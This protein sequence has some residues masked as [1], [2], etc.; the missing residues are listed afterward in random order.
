MMSS[1]GSSAWRYPVTVISSAA[2]GGRSLR[3]GQVVIGRRH[4]EEPRRELLVFAIRPRD[5]RRAPRRR[6]SPV[7]TNVP[8]VDAAGGIADERP[9]RFELHAPSVLNEQRRAGLG[10]DQQHDQRLDD[11][12]TEIAGLQPPQERW[13]ES[14]QDRF[15]DAIERRA[16]ERAVEMTRPQE[17]GDR[18]ASPRPHQPARLLSR[19]GS[20][21][22]TTRWP[23]AP[24]A[25]A[26]TTGTSSRR[27]R[28]APGPARLPAT[29]A[30]AQ[31]SGC[32]TACGFRIH[33]A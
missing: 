12:T 31:P 17:R 30:T 3:T 16:V 23:A 24:R 9:R 7:C 4:V 32:R 21:Q 15:G 8:G 26:C 27:T 14:D 10:D 13:Q 19:R 2:Y 1:P 6:R 22:R 20:W 11:S 28:S 29:G 5:D 18:H 33:R 25:G